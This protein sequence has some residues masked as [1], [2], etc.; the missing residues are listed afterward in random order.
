MGLEGY[1]KHG[2]QKHSKK[3]SVCVCVDVC[4]FTV[5]MSASMKFDPLQCMCISFTV[6]M[7]PCDPTQHIQQI[8][9]VCEP[10]ACMCVHLQ[11]FTLAYVYVYAYESGLVIECAQVARVISV[12]DRMMLGEAVHI[13]PIHIGEA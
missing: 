9:Y 6:K 11:A 4:V 10:S 2:L 1:L 5:D 7:N 13:N 12:S 3:Y 8:Q